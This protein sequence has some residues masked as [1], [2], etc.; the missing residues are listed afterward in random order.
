[1]Q[2]LVSTVTFVVVDGTS[3]NGSQDSIPT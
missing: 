3:G 1:M 2:K